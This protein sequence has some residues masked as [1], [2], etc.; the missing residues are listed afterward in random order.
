MMYLI[1]TVHQDIEIGVGPEEMGR[2]TQLL[3]QMYA[4]V[5]TCPKEYMRPRGLRYQLFWYAIRN[6]KTRS[7][8]RGESGEERRLL[9]G[10]A[11]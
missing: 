9:A 1:W 11:S 3:C 4:Y 5:F 2:C 7:R 8:E 10:A 6:L